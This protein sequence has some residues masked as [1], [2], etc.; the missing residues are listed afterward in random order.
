MCTIDRRH[1]RPLPF[2]SNHKQICHIFELHHHSANVMCIIYTQLIQAVNRHDSHTA[3]WMLSAFKITS[4]VINVYSNKK[5]IKVLV[6]LPNK[7]FLRWPEILFIISCV[8]DTQ[9][10]YAIFDECDECGC[11]LFDLYS[12]LLSTYICVLF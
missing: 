1:F 4:T 2:A 10:H 3:N 12:I 6:I 5:R 8:P 9:W 11:I 7:R